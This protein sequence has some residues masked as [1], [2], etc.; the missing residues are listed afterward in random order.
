[1][2]APT[3]QC[4]N[5]TN[6]MRRTTHGDDKSLGVEFEFELSCGRYVQVCVVLLVPYDGVTQTKGFF[7]HITDIHVVFY[8]GNLD[9]IY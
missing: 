7:H 1:M 5:V 3:A 2:D 6:A 8:P 4:C 9:Y